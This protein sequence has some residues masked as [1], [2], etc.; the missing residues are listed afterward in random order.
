VQYPGADFVGYRDGFFGPEQDQEVVA[1][2]R[3]KKPH[4]LFVARSADNQDMWIHQH[5]GQLDIPLMMGVGGSIDVVSG[6]AKRAPRLFQKLRLE[7]FYRLAKEP[8][9]YK[10]M[11]ALPKFVWKVLRGHEKSNVL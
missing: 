5:R 1:S 6:K 10:R 2:I 11:L 4:L 3:E 7:W 9:R 8:F